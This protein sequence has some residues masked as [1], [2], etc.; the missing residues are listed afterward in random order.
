VGAYIRKAVKPFSA[1]ENTESSAKKLKTTC[2]SVSEKCL[3]EK[4]GVGSN[5]QNHSGWSFRA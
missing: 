4:E 5:G 3:I 2:H 1:T